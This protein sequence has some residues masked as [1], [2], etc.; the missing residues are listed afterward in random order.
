MVLA[1]ILIMY[2]QGRIE[3]KRACIANKQ[4][5]VR[6]NPVL[7]RLKIV[8]GLKL[9]SIIMISIKHILLGPALFVL[10]I[11]KFSLSSPPSLEAK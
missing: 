5:Y 4:T 2:S 8:V 10:S 3:E 7:R 6:R 1:N 11:E 9:L